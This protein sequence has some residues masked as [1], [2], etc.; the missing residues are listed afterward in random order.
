MEKSFARKLNWKPLFNSLIFG[1]AIGTFIFILTGQKLDAGIVFGIVAFF[2]QSSIIYPRSL[3]TLYGFWRITEKDVYYY[4]YSTWR[5]RIVG[6]FL[7]LI[8][9]QD[10]VSFDNIESY[11]LVV[12]KNNSSN[13]VTP[14]YIVLRLDNGHNVAL[15][16]SWNLKKSGAPEKDVEWVVDFIN[17]KL[18]QKTVEIFQV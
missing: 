4:D 7:P 5:K 3:P 8:K 2:I 6:I 11:S 14:H 13:K 15:D 10:V 17:D 1:A 16:L 9:K 12:N 18:N